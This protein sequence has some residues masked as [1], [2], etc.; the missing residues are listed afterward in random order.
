M[1]LARR[2]VNVIF[3]MLKDGTTYNDNHP[4]Q[5][6]AAYPTP[7]HHHKPIAQ[8]TTIGPKPCPK[9]HTPNQG[10]TTLPTTC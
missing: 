9:T 4:H 3:R 7:L 1:C 8:A 5:Q 10:Q 6:Q 2:K